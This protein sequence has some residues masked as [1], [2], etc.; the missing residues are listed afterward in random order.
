MKVPAAGKYTFIVEGGQNFPYS[1]KETYSF[2]LDGKVISE[3]TLD[4]GKPNMGN[5]TVAPGASPTAPPVMS[6]SKPATIEVNMTDTEPHT[7]K[8]E[9]SG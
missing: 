9:Y 4:A 6:G 8:L 5:F 2:T 1:P 7:F 3:G